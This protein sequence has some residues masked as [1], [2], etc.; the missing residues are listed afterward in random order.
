MLFTQDNGCLS[1]TERWIIIIPLPDITH[2]VNS[3]MGD[4][5]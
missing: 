1:V 5:R 4:F 3:V 2:K